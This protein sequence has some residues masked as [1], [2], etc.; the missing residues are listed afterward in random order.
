MRHYLLESVTA[1]PGTLGPVARPGG[2]VSRCCC[3]LVWAKDL[4]KE[5]GKEEKKTSRFSFRSAH[6]RGGQRTRGGAGLQ[7]CARARH[8]ELKDELNQFWMSAVSAATRAAA[9]MPLGQFLPV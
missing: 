8:L 1:L 6:G 2:D 9:G 4:R 7:P 3:P 5:A